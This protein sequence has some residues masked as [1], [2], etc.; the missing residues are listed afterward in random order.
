[1]HLSASP[2]LTSTVDV[3]DGASGLNYAYD[4]RDFGGIMVPTKRRAYPSDAQKHK[5]PE[6]LLVEIDI[7]DIEFKGA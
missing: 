4:Y 3:L 5:V 7:N 6:P 1:M 2:L